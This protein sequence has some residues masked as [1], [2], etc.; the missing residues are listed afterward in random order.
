MRTCRL[1]RA[2]RLPW[3]KDR[4]GDCVAF[5]VLKRRGQQGMRTHVDPRTCP[6]R[7]SQRSPPSRARRCRR[8]T[9]DL[10]LLESGLDSLCF[11][12]LGQPAGRRDRPRSVL[13]GESLG[14]SAHRRRIDRVLRTRACLTL[15]ASRLIAR[16]RR[17]RRGEISTRDHRPG[18]ARISRPAPPFGG[19]RS[20]SPAAAS[21]SRCA[22]WPRPPRR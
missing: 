10:P 19:D 11:A 4:A 8:S 22:T 15:S 2:A 7:N 1:R 17:R 3:V 21:C 9:D 12:I 14:I 16:A 13:V 5:E 6:R 20:A 18:A